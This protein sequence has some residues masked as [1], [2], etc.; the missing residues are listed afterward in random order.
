MPVVSVSMPDELVER[1]DEFA[2]EHDYTGRS[3]LVRDGIRTHLEEFDDHRLENRLLAGVV[4]ACYAFGSS[5][6]DRRLTRL[7]HDYDDAITATDHSHVGD[8]CLE[9]F[10]LE[11]DLECV[12]T[13]VRQLQ[14]VDGVEAVDTS[15]VPLEAGDDC[16]PE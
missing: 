12:E 15:L 3:D 13:V 4:C 11:G 14:S 1:L 8:S 5:D 6:V 9:L 16:R 10:V 2:A 7:R